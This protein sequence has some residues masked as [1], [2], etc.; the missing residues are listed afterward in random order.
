MNWIRDRVIDRTDQLVGDSLWFYKQ[1][2]LYVDFSVTMND[3]SKFVSFLGN[4]QIDYMNPQFGKEARDQARQVQS[5]SVQV[6]KNAG[7][8]DEA[9]WN[10]AR[11][12]KLSEK[13]QNIYNMVDSIKNVPMYNTIYNIINTAVSGYLETK[14]VAFGPY[15]RLYSFNNIEGN[16]VSFGVRTTSELSRKFR[17]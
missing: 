6:M 11:P 17:L 4:R 9:W 8:K 1:D 3:S 12:Y 16:R 5:S 13:E 15:S 2:K 10:E 14:Y 7:R